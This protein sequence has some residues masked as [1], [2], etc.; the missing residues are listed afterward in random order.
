MGSL[1]LRAQ[2]VEKSFPGVRALDKVDFDL[3]EGEVHILLGK[4]RRRKID[5][6]ENIQRL[7]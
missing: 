4:K 1:I 5:A 2:G 6:D 7:R 3:E